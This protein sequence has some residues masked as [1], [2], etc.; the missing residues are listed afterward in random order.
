MR[1]FEYRWLTELVSPSSDPAADLA[2]REITSLGQD[3]WEMVAVVP[4]EGGRV[5]IFFK[6][7]LT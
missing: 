3:G 7:E 5:T 4:A 6:R 2:A 1:R